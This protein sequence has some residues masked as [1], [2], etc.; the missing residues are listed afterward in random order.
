MNSKIAINKIKALL[1]SFMAVALCYA[2][3]G[4]KVGAECTSDYFG[5]IKG[6][7][8]A[9]VANQTSVLGK[10]HLIDTLK[11]SGFDIVKAFAPEH[12]LRGKEDAG[13]VVTSG[14]D[15]KTG[16]KVVSIYGKVKK[17]TS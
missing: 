14:V 11:G 9:V 16:V 8:I 1:L 10:V 2:N 13:A 7:R 15:V 6:K 3:D 12:G 17:P 5:V 4:V